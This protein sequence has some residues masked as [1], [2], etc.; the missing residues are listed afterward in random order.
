MIESHESMNNTQLLL[1]QFLVP[2]SIILVA[3]L[4]GLCIEYIFIRFLR[5]VLPK[6]PGEYDDLVFRI[7]SGG[8]ATFWCLL[9]GTNEALKHIVLLNSTTTHTIRQSIFILF[10]LSVMVAISRLIIGIVNL[11][12]ISGEARSPSLLDNSIRIAIF[13]FGFLFIL[14][15][16]NVQITP[17]LAA[18]GAGSLGVSLALQDTL[19]SLFSGIQIMLTRRIRPGNYVKLSSGEEGYV[20]DINWHSTQITQWDNNMVVVPN[21][22]LTNALITNFYDPS[23]IMIVW[24]DVRVGYRS[25]LEHVEQLTTEV[26][27]EVIV[28]TSVIKV[29]ERGF[30]SA[31]KKQVIAIVEKDLYQEVKK[32]V[33]EA[34][35]Q[36]NVSPKV[37][38]RI[39]TLFEKGLMHVEI[40]EKIRTIIKKDV[41]DVIVEGIDDEI[42]NILEKNMSFKD[43]E[44][45]VQALFRKGTFTEETKQEITNMMKQAM[46]FESL[47][48]SILDILEKSH[49][50]SEMT[51]EVKAAL[52]KGLVFKTIKQNVTDV[53]KKNLTLEG[54]KEEIKSTLRRFEKGQVPD[55]VKQ[56]VLTIIERIF[57]D[58]VRSEIA[59]TLKQGHISENIT[60]NIVHTLDRLFSRYIV[61]N[62]RRILDTGIPP[63]QEPFIRYNAFADFSINFSVF[64]YIQEF[65][66]QYVLKHEIIK[67]LH[68]RYH[69]EGIQIPYPSHTIYPSDS[70]PWEL[71]ITE[72]N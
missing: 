63:D 61:T 32:G 10:I 58:N 23:P 66:A 71:S 28:A 25:N 26:V 64:F 68:T 27:K 14:G 30:L 43:K 11:S 40:R 42:A 62:V 18:V 50:S 60:E 51:H 69:E 38:K 52:A 72:R 45:D 65:M 57:T 15:S 70:T 36:H 17:L 59:A 35:N 29:L 44:R 39:A 16:F 67:R 46:T 6:I 33:L 5:N 9:L 1:E 2:I 3:L 21:T 31:V 19:S 56:T 37:H 20:T 8:M 49:A 13:T 22:S 41:Q 7:L 4:I 12:S 48:Q 53:L 24:I 54:V 47:E 34:L 55:S